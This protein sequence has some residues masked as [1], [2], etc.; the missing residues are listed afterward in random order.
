MSDI[1]MACEE[2]RTDGHVFVSVVHTEITDLRAQL[3]ETDRRSLDRLQQNS[4]LDAENEGLRDRLT[5]AKAQLA[6]AQAERDRLRLAD[7]GTI[8][9]LK[10]RLEQAQAGERRLREALKS[11]RLSLMAWN[12]MKCS[13]RDEVEAAEISRL[14]EQ[15][16][17]IRAID[18]ALAEPEAG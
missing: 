1:C 16:P 6:Q 12:S 14:Y 2:G 18:A 4:L 13:D 11:A 17:E 9:N 3:A 5:K 8:L 7:D 15:S 10:T